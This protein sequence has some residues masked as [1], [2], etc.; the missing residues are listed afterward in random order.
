MSKA[1][2]VYFSVYGTA[3]KTAEEIARQ[4]GADLMEIEPVVPYGSDSMKE[5]YAK[6]HDLYE[7][8]GLSDKE[9][10]ELIVLDVKDQEYFSQRGFAD[11]HGG[12][13]AFA[14]DPAILGWLFNKDNL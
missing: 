4:T 2:V 11:Q 7:Q 10:N 13:M 5:A 3:K 9:I 6:L 1:L 8:Q 14:K 12:G